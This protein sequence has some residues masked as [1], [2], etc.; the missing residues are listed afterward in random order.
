MVLRYMLINFF[1]IF[2][3]C[4]QA[5]PFD[6]S[7]SI[8]GGNG[9]WSSGV[10]YIDPDATVSFYCTPSGGTAP[11][12]YSWD[13]DHPPK[14]AEIT[15]R[16]DWDTDED[17]NT[18]YDEGDEHWL[19]Y[20]TEQNPTYQFLYVADYAATVHVKDAAGAVEKSIIK[21]SAPKLSGGSYT[22]YNAVTDIGLNGNGSTDNTNTFQTWI[23]ALGNTDKAVVVFP[24]GNYRFEGGVNGDTDWEGIAFGVPDALVLHGETPSGATLTLDIPY[25][26]NGGDCEPGDGACDE[27]SDAFFRNN[28]SS[29][30]HIFTYRNLNLTRDLNGYTTGDLSST[31][32]TTCNEGSGRGTTSIQ[33]CTITNFSVPASAMVTHH[34]VSKNNAI[35]WGNRN[36]SSTS[37][38]DNFT[39]GQGY[40]GIANALYKHNYIKTSTRSSHAF[41]LGE[42]E[43]YQYIVSNFVDGGPSGVTQIKGVQMFTTSGTIYDQSYKLI[44][45]NHYYRFQDGFYNRADENPHD[46][47]FFDNSLKSLSRYG[48]DMVNTKDDANANVEVKYNLFETVGG[49]VFNLGEESWQ[50]LSDLSFV[51]NLIKGAAGN[52]WGFT[53]SDVSGCVGQES[54]LNPDGCT[55]VLTA[56]G[57]STTETGT[58]ITDPGA[59]AFVAPTITSRSRSGNA[60]TIAATGGSGLTGTRWPHTIGAWMQVIDSAGNHS[61]I[62]A[63]STDETTWGMTPEDI[64]VADKDHNVSAPYS[65]RQHSSIGTVGGGVSMH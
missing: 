56:T 63:Y 36:T 38:A 7:V 43:D 23:Q 32:L 15:W 18:G 41:Y 14:G 25:D 42:G 46:L 39:H 4:S 28:M 31:S 47:Y 13:F 30:G 65:F 50:N 16:R 2:F 22:V 52:I 34:I 49:N 1:L 6:L 21:L 5:F 48:V 11:Y 61:Q 37:S 8:S 51:G 19:E 53:S 64:R 54:I 59:W 10:Y 60:T 29:H 27:V 45:G 44:L 12:S 24:D 57:N 9:Y 62:K 33:N 35:D 40:L 20:S 58:G 26:S 17:S 55:A 3:V